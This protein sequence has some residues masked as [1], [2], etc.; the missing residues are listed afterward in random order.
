MIVDS[1]GPVL[2]MDIFKRGKKDVLSGKIRK[3]CGF[4]RYNIEK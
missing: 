2:E 1:K 4:E 3:T